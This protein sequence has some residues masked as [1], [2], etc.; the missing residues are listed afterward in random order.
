MIAMEQAAAVLLLGGNTWRDIRKHSISILLTAGVFLAA[1]FLRIWRG[2]YAALA[3]GILPG[4]CLLG[5]SWMT[6]QAL[7]Y[8][9]GLVESVLGALLGWKKAVE[10]LMGAFLLAAVFSAAA[11]AAHRL[12]RKSELP[13]LPFFLGAYLILL[14]VE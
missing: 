5:L 1:V 12:G 4:I 10:I 2:E 7:G 11:L 8:G 9:D 14:A 3:A 6:K 13:F